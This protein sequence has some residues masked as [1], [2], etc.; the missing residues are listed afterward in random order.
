MAALFTVSY[1]IVLVTVIPGMVTIAVIFGAFAYVNPYLLENLSISFFGLEDW[2]AIAIAVTIMILTQTLGILL[3]EILVRRK[4][5]GRKK[6]VPQETD[7]YDEYGIL[8]YILA[9]MKE[10]DDAHGHLRRAI[11]QFFLTLNTLISFLIG[12]VVAFVIA[13]FGKPESVMGHER[14]GIY[15]TFMALCFI[16]SYIV[17]RLRFREMARS[18]W[19][20]RKEVDVTELIE[21]NKATHR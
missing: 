7:C 3:E 12:A 13:F 4:W 8:Y 1:W 14:A 2:L 19:A 17:T 6:L 11:A 10:I 20:V 15:I 5:L 21:A 9:E 18:I 16:A